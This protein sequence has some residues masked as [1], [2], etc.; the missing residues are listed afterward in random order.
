MPPDFPFLK[1]IDSYLSFNRVVGP[2]IYAVT[3]VIIGM[4]FQQY[5]P[6]RTPKKRIIWILVFAAACYAIFLLCG[7]D[8]SQSSYW[9]FYMLAIISTAYV[10]LYWFI[11]V[12]RIKRWAGFLLPV[13]RNVI[14][15][16]FLSHAV[17]PLLYAM[18]IHSINDYFNSGIIGIVRTVLYTVALT[19]LASL[20][21]TRC[22]M[23]LR[24]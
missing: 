11:D 2:S 15:V 4:L 10:L 3:G 16:Y 1:T 21:T 24:L 13:G 12:C 22:H 23:K 19:L 5:S 9:R 6:A 18:G 17:H 8:K 20:L 14:L 7:T